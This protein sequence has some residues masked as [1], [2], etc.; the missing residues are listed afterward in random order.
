VLA[1]K[2]EGDFL[3]SPFPMSNL[4]ALLV[5]GASGTTRDELRKLLDF[6]GEDNDLVK[7]F[8]RVVSDFQVS[9][10]SVNYDLLLY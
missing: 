8:K 10:I 6:S 7:D 5:T 1:E 4:L 3:I 9:Y 2:V